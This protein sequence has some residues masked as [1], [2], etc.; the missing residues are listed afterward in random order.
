M[1]PHYLHVFATATFTDVYV[2][3]TILPEVY[4]IN[5]VNRIFRQV[6]TIKNPQGTWLAFL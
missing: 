6:L 1:L 2:K 4:Y 5:Y 3:C